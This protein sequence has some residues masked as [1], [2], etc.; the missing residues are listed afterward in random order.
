MAADCNSSVK[1]MNF[2]HSLSKLFWAVAS[3]AVIS[4]E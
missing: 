4:V 1:I 3:L 2:G